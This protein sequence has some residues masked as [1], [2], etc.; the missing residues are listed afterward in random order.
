MA[1]RIRTILAVVVCLATVGFWLYNNPV[2]RLGWCQFGYSTYNACP[3]PVSDFQVRADG[4]VRK[5]KKTHDLGL[6]QVEWLLTPMPEVLIIGTGWDGGTAVSDAVRSQENC[7]VQ[8]LKSDAARALYNRLKDEGRRV[9]LH[10]H[11]TC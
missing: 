4:K 6:D 10:F 2:G 9:A 8:V 1:L 5:V 11:S 7:E 3:R